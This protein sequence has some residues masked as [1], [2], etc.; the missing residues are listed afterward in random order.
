MSAEFD[1]YAP[2]YSDLLSDPLRDRFSGDSEFFHQRKWVLI[3]DFLARHRLRPSSLNWLDVGCGEGD[4]L[5]LGGKHFARAAGC[6]PSSGMIRSCGDVEVLEQPSP[7]ELP[8]AA[9]TFDFVTAVCVYHHVPGS[10]RPAL[11]NSIRRVLKPGGVFCMIEHNPW[12][13]VTRLIVSRCAV[14]RDAELLTS[15]HAA[16]VYRA[17]GFGILETTHFLYLPRPLFR[18]FG[19]V[20]NYLKWLPL[21]GQFAVFGTRTVSGS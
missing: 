9:Q 2:S 19:A 15:V 21:G 14:D 13:P 17:A 16:K 6:D 8:F 18:R 11:T 10:D 1:R 20:E 7:V 4:L 12:N 5:K 3:R